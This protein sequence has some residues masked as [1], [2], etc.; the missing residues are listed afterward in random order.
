MSLNLKQQKKLRYIILKK[1]SDGENSFYAKDF[2]IEKD[3]FCNITISLEKL[4]YVRNSNFYY[5]GQ[6]ETT[7]AIITEK[8]EK[9]LKDNSVWGKLVNGFKTLNEIKNFLKVK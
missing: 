4:G 2:D 1:M 7:G 8:G 6:F 5:S 3:D 9:F